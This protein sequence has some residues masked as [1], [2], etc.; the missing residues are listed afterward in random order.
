ME[1][2]EGSSCFL[3]CG[4]GAFQWALF[5]FLLANFVCSFSVLKATLGLQY[6][7]TKI[8]GF[9]I[10]FPFSIGFFPVIWIEYLEFFILHFYHPMIRKLVSLTLNIDKI[11]NGSSNTIVRRKIHFL[12]MCANC[13]FSVFVHFLSGFSV[14]PPNLVRFCGF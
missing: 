14:L 2:G 9:G 11:T 7:H 13:G 6:R 12:V 3:L 1:E 4:S 5:R 10:R 8:D